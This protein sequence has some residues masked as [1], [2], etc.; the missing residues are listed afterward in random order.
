[1]KY[2][3]KL[4]LELIYNIIKNAYGICQH[5]EERK[6]FVCVCVDYNT[7]GWKLIQ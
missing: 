6:G 4:A 5:V 3:S 7:A 2:L 1:M